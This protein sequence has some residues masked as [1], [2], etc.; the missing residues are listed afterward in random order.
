MILY[1]Y[2]LDNSS[3]ITPIETRLTTI[4]RELATFKKNS[5]LFFNTYIINNAINNT[6]IY[7]DS[8]S[9][10]ITIGDVTQCGN[11]IICAAIS[12]IGFYVSDITPRSFTV[13]DGDGLKCLLY[14]FDSDIN[15]QSV[16]RENKV[17]ILIPSTQLIDLK[18]I[19]VTIN[20]NQSVSRFTDRLNVFSDNLKYFFKFEK[21]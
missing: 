6:Y 18:T 3:D 1:T 20:L 9:L 5:N 17:C 21:I 10:Y 7:Y 11:E 14:S 16:I 12:G 15:P 4:E 2:D 13:Y 19:K 8:T